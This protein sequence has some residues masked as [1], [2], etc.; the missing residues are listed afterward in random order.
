M[1]YTR[2]TRI[3]QALWRIRHWRTIKRVLSARLCDD[4]RV[5]IMAHATGADEAF[6]WGAMR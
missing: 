4:D 5:Y 2:K 6:V 1:R 3:K